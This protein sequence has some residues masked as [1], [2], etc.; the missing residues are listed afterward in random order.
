MKTSAFTRLLLIGFDEQ[1]R[2]DIVRDVAELAENRSGWRRRAYF[3][4]EVAKYP[5]RCLWERAGERVRG[6]SSRTGRGGIMERWLHDIRYAVRSL[7][8]SRGFTVTALVILSLGMGATTAIYSVV[9]GVLLDPL[10]LDEPER[11]VSVWLDSPENGRARMTP[12]A[13]SATLAAAGLF[14]SAAAFQGRSAS[15]LL[16]GQATFVRGGAVTVDYFRTLGVHPL[17]GRTFDADEAAAGAAPVVVISDGLWRNAFGGD[18]DIVGRGVSLDDV[19]HEVVGVI[20]ASVLPTGAT[21]SAELTFTTANQDFFVPLIYGADLWQNFRPHILGMV[22]RLLPGQNLAV[23]TASMS[24]VDEQLHDDG[25]LSAEHLL[26]T[27][28]AE[29]VV[30]DVR[31]A[32]WALLGS[33]GLVLSIAIANVGALFVLRTDDRRSELA[34]R[35]ALGA[36]RARILRQL[37]LESALVA[38]AAGVIAVVVAR[39]ALEGMRALVPYQIPRMEDVTLSSTS[40]VVTFGL[41]LA[42]ALVFA[43]LPVLS[44]DRTST[45][46]ATQRRQTASRSQRRL[47]SVLVGVQAAL[48]VIVL[49]GAGLL[50]RSYGE[51]RSV[52]TGFDARETWAMTVPT[53]PQVLDQVVAELREHPAVAGATV[54]YDHPLE[55]NWGDSFQVPDPSAPSALAT[56]S[57]SLRI[58]GSDYFEV[59]GI[60]VLNGRVPG[61]SDLAGDRALAVVNQALADAWFP[62]GRAVG[63]TLVVPTAARVNGDD[64][65]FEII[66]VVENVR[67]LGPDQ[68]VGPAFYLPQS[69]FA[70]TATTL[71]VR[72]VAGGA[73]VMGVVREVVA[74]AAPGVAIQRPQR[75]G[76]I[77]ADLI[78]RPR[79]NMML[80]VTFGAMVLVL[81]GLGA[82]G[83][84]GR[85][86]ATRVREIG[87]RMAL[88]AD[89]SGL[90]RSVLGSALRPMFVGGVGGVVVAL[91][92]S[93]LIQSLLFGIGARDPLSLVLGPVF[94][95]LVGAMA[96]AVPTLR[97]LAIDPAA[98]L[99][100]E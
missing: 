7:V 23:A 53:Q 31:L 38:I 44:R 75:L 54:A 16:D 55:R 47:Q 100:E 71:L 49:A 92:A 29:E 12:G 6:D 67:F 80:L 91:V 39:F 87:I 82:Y 30:G 84:V 62:A 78:A 63:S 74:Q 2:A 19:L 18:P 36:S 22:G 66:G 99:R 35:A 28:F 45:N 14:E 9:D 70:Q 96:A 41:G 43:L 32:L 27:P 64:G 46:R 4:V 5:I 57:G 86:V 90:A 98:S 34:I 69:H 52:D 81:C 76:D 68:P 73:D 25:L 93:G 21:V 37:L 56:G 95:V 72:P 89:R 26:L 13:Y 3:W 60:R 15:L 50:T 8:R 83:L 65:V 51:L 58:F 20:P 59:V 42:V 79:F 94:V 24:A 10:P 40:L 11:V 97:A 1:E 61:P 85:V 88:G 77:H 48:G 33:V 17:L